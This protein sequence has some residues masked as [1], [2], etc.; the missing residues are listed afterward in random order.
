MSQVEEEEMPT[1]ELIEL[2]DE[3]ISHIQVRQPDRTHPRPGHH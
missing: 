2:N 1:L 3:M